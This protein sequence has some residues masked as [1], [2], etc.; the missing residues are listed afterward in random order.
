MSWYD[1][2]NPLN[3]EGAHHPRGKW[4]IYDISSSKATNIEV[5][6]E[7]CEC[8]D[9]WLQLNSTNLVR[10]DFQAHVAGNHGSS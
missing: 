7:L 9:L 5:L 4:D 8:V 2:I 6:T 10:L 3:P 1:R